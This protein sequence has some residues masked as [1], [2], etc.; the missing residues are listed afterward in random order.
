MKKFCI[1]GGCGC[2]VT[3]LSV[4]DIKNSF[5]TSVVS[6]LDSG[7]STGIIR[8]ESGIYALGDLRANLLAASENNALKEIMSNR[9]EVNGQKHNVGNLVLL[10][11]IKI[12]GAK[13]L[14]HLQCALGIAKNIR[15]VPVID[16]VNYKGN[17][18]IKSDRGVFVG[19]HNLDLQQ[20]L[21]VLDIWLDSPIR[22]G[23]N[24]SKA[25][26]SAD[27]I[28]FGPGDL[29]SSILANV[30]VPGFVDAVNA[31][32][33]KKILVCNIM[34]KDNET[35][36]FKTSDFFDAFKKHGIELDKIIY[37]NKNPEIKEITSKYGRL[38]G[39]V[40]NDMP[41]D[42]II[43]ADLVNKDIPY[44]HD[45]KKL[46]RLMSKVLK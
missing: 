39:F 37:N 29:Y 18:V 9:I 21:R 7:G 27:Y 10:S 5:T 42:K 44:E 25:I 35:I 41:N 34:M 32:K 45:P 20:D 23:E 12:Y 14:D 36:G 3:L 4:R 22:I 46:K 15:I 19:E 1:V 40:E 38:K 33:A 31:S 43:S 26:T 17:L 11:A 8:R 30:I 13:Y 28:I 2:K 24:A 16:D 6:V